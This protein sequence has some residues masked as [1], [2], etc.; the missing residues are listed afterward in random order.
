ML[1]LNGE[2]GELLKRIN[3][4]PAAHNTLVS[5]NGRF[6]YLGSQTMLT[7]FDT[8]N[9]KLSARSRTWASAGY[10]PTRG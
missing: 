2:N 9:E 6:L 10:F 1:V 8:R 7:I 3:V 5:L 4:G